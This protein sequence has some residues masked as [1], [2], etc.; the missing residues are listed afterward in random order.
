ML[1]IVDNVP[2][3]FTFIDKHGPLC[4]AETEMLLI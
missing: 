2:I 1:F 4:I 3:G